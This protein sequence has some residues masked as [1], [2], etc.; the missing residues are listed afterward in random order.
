MR[1]IMFVRW[2]QGFYIFDIIKRFRD[3]KV[4]RALCF[5]FSFLT[6]FF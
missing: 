1:L 3:W 5:F 6:I 2:C 4:Y